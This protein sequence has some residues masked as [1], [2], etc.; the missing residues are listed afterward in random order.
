MEFADSKGTTRS[1]ISR[2]FRWYTCHR[3]TPYARK[4]YGRL[5]FVSRCLLYIT[6]ASRLIFW[7]SRPPQAPL[8]CSDWQGG[9]C[10]HWCIIFQQ[11]SLIPMLKP[12]NFVFVT[13]WKISGSKC[14]RPAVVLKSYID[15]WV[16]NDLLPPSMG[17]VCILKEFDK[18]VS[19]VHCK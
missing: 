17:T 8:G 5:K 11:C 12:S 16:L 1:R 3:R 10:G 4:R 18:K 14:P 7:T 6:I 2:A 9:Y 19:L 13:F 15:W